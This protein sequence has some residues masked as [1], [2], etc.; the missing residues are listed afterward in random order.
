MKHSGVKRVFGLDVLR[1]VAILFVMAL[2]GTGLL[3][4]TGIGGDLA[5]WLELQTGV[6]GV[7]GVEIFFVLSGFLIGTILLSLA[8]SFK[9]PKILLAFW[10]RRWFRTLPNYFLF[11]G[12]N[13]AVLHFLSPSRLSGTIPY[14]LFLQNWLWIQPR[15]FPESWSLAIEEWFYLLFPI[16]IFTFRRRLSYE[17]AFIVSALIFLVIPTILRIIWAFSGHTDWD[18]EFRKV[19]MLRLDSIMYGVMAAQIKIIFPDF[20]AKFKSIL[21]VIGLGILFVAWLYIIEVGLNDWFAKTL[22]FSVISLGASFLLPFCDQW[23][24]SKENIITHSFRQTALWS[25]SL[26]LCHL[27]VLLIVESVFP[28][29]D[30]QAIPLSIAAWFAFYILSF[31]IA[32]FLYRYF[33]KPIMDLRERFPISVFV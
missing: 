13:M 9:N 2:H 30:R 28:L 15:F 17:R 8:P 16:V 7:Y 14:F 12:I 4:S 3:V 22:L 5:S 29:L 33:E 26:Y 6:L 21:L 10:Q 20:W 11:L 18:G 25:Y 23:R 24:V 32:G 31:A 27:S 1:A 19:T